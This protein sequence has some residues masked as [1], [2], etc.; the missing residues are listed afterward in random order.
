MTYKPTGAG[1]ARTGDAFKQGSL[2]GRKG[3]KAIFDQCSSWYIV[4]MTFQYFPRA[5]RRAGEGDLCGAA[6]SLRRIRM[7][8]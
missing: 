4:A 8:I 6:R 3:F 2:V 1:T 7:S 5:K